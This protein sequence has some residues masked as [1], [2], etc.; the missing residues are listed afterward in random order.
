MAAILQFEINS[1]ETEILT[2]EI[3]FKK[4]ATLTL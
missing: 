2:Q 1:Y 3:N 4:Y